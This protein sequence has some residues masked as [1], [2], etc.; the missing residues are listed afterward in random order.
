[1]AM[2]DPKHDAFYVW[3]MLLGIYENEGGGRD[4]EKAVEAAYRVYVH[5]LEQENSK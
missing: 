1:M 3:Q 4:R 2:N 5:F